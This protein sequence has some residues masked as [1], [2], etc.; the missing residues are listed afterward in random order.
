MCAERNELG[1]RELVNREV[2]L[3]V[4]LKFV[5]TAIVCAV[6]VTLYEFRTRLALTASSGV[7]AFQVGLLLYL[8]FA[9]RRWPN[10]IDI[11]D[12]S[13]CAALIG[14]CS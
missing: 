14:S 9:E 12:E 13:L 11:L 4:S 8:T 5:G 3:F 6:L 1:W 10:T 7:T 2:W